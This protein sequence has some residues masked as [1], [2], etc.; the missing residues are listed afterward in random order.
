MQMTTDA[1]GW[2]GA[3]VRRILARH[4]LGDAERAG[5]TYELMSHLHAAGEAR[6]TAAGRSEVTR[7]D[8]EAALA[9]AGGDDGLA[10][11][12]VQPLAK[13]VERVLFGRRLGAFA[14][15]ALLLGIVLTFVH[16]MLVFLLEPLM[17]GMGAASRHVDLRWLIPWGYHDPTLAFAL[18][19]VIALASAVTVLGYFTWFDAHEGRSPGKRA[20][21]LRVVRVDGR[22]MTYRESFIRNLVKV[23]PPLL[24]LDTLFMLI[25]F[26]DDKQRVSDK[27]AETVVVRA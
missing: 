8:L 1:R 6:A 16:G 3:T 26:G 12:F 5:I 22:P 17:G 10:T 13:P 20:L 21:E 11:A 18:Q 7:E 27:I 2:L 25:A 19:A 15:D 24:F 23:V 9:E 14:I 4:P